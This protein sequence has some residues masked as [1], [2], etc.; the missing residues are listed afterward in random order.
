MAGTDRITI[1]Q[2]ELLDAVRDS[3]SKA[4]ADGLMIMKEIAVAL[5][6]GLDAT[7]RRVAAAI[8][9]G[10]MFHSPTYRFD[11]DGK[12]SKR[13]GYGLTESETDT[14]AANPKSVS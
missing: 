14:K 11:I 12:E 8:K 3:T 4:E 6:M 13:A 5:D 9:S 7:R 10:A 1:K 2:Q